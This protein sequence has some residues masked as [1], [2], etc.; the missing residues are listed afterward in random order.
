LTAIY[1][2]QS[3]NGHSIPATAAQG[4][5]QQY[6]VLADSLAFDLSGQVR[7]TYTV[8]WISTAPPLQDTVYTQTMTFPYSIERNKLTIGFQQSCGPA[9]N[10]VGWEEGTID[11]TTARVID[12][13]FWSGSHDLV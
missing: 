13:I 8:R 4:A 5:G 2:L 7:R 1:V 6:V 9:A 12:R 3:V 11:A 10:C